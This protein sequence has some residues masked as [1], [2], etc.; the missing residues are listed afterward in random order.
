M[1]Y[2][3]RGLFSEFYSIHLSLRTAY[4]RKNC[5]FPGSCHRKQLSGVTEKGSKLVGLMMM[6]MLIMTIIILLS[7]TKSE[8]IV[9]TLKS[10]KN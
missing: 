6:M 10:V 3:P 5:C 2:K 1:K 8:I 7:L 4:A 9:F